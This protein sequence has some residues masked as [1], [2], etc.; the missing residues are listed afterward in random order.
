MMVLRNDVSS[1]TKARDLGLE[2]DPAGREVVRVVGQRTGKLAELR[3]DGQ[4]TQAIGAEGDF[5]RRWAER[6][7][8]L[9]GLGGGSQPNDQH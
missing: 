7:A 3:V 1:V 8:A 4:H 6:D 5:A 2:F 9:R